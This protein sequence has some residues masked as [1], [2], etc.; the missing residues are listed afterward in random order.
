VRD[1]FSMLSR[2]LLNSSNFFK[3]SL[4]FKLV[5]I[6]TLSFLC[7]MARDLPALELIILDPALE[8]ALS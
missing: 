7:G 4:V 1:Y 6:E 2:I 5:R 3:I 8:L